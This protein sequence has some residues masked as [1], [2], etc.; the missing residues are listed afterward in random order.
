MCI[1]GSY[2]KKEDC[3]RSPCKI[4]QDYFCPSEKKYS[5]P[6]GFKH[7]CGALSEKYESQTKPPIVQSKQ[8]CSQLCKVNPMCLGFEYVLQPFGKHPQGSCITNTKCPDFNV[9]LSVLN[10]CYKETVPFHLFK[11]ENN[12]YAEDPE[13]CPVK[14]YDGKWKPRGECTKYDAFKSEET[15]IKKVDEK[16]GEVEE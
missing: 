10:V 15:P 9:A 5:C 7:V 11:C 3:N 1:D 16:I 8:A 4:S 14:C 6:L 13:D 12:T 2:K